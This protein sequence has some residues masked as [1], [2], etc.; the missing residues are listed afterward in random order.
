MRMADP[1][2]VAAVADALV[3]M[4]R[5]LR[6]APAAIRRARPGSPIA[7]PAIPCRHAGS[8]DVFLE[9]LETAPRGGVLVIDNEAREDEACI[10]DLVVAE[11][12][13]AGLAGIVVWGLH[14]DSV[15][16]RSIDLPVW[17]LGT[18]PAGPRGSRPPAPAGT[19]VRIGELVVGAGD[20]VA[21]DD[22]GVLLVDWAD[23]EAAS[24]SAASIVE[25]EAAQAERITSGTAL[26]DQ[27]RF[28]EY[29]ER[30]RSDPAY[31]LREHLRTSGGAIET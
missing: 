24:R 29:L 11:C 3:R 10:G 15:A 7:G 22:D 13:L 19:P 25:A 14:R 4:G 12:R 20:V 8:V 30:R 5:P 26:R 1:L 16:L 23:W 31:T 27:L 21:A 2:P 6:L 17:S 28:G 9:A 18:V